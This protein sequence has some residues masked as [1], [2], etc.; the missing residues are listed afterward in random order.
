M[1]LANVGSLGTAA[2]AGTGAT[3]LVMTTGATL[4]AGNAGVLIAVSDNV[5]A[6][7]NTNDHT[8]VVDSTGSNTYTKI[9][10]NTYSLA[11]SAADGVTVSIWTVKAASQLTSG[12]TVT[13]SWS[14]TIN[15][16]CATFEEFT[17]TNALELA[18]TPPQLE[19]SAAS[20]HPISRT[21]S[22]L[23]SQEYL[24]VRAV[25]KE[26]NSTTVLTATSGFA[27]FTGTRSRN[28]AAAT[29]VRGEWDIATGTGST[30]APSMNVISDTTSIFVALKEGAGGGG[31]AFPHHY[32]QLMRA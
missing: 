4:E 30:S 6:T 31:S 18:Q 15:D 3:S 12:G 23:S 8:G 11:G 13:M 5:S 21:I 14:A 2:S 27:T 19:Q 22:S 29:L 26:I 28:N 25:G 1:A 24:F 10:E 16:S 17:L 7:G 9:Y 20:S 32:Y